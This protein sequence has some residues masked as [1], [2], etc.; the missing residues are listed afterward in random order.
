MTTH[1]FRSLLALVVLCLGLVVPADAGGPLALRAPGQ[2][3]RWPNGGLMIPF[4]PDQGG[5]GPLN[6][7]QAVAQTTAAFA[8]WE[9]IPSASATHVNAGTLAVDVDETN[10]M[11]F[12]DA[13]RARR[14]QRHRLRRGRR[15]LQPAVRYRT[16]ASSASPVP[17]G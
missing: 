7:A 10:F 6:N 15:D 16:P 8:A 13:A 12:F 4:N 9:A 2:P 1:A 5:L 11:P 17:N 14:P 3:F